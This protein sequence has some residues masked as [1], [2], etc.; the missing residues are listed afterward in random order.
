MSQFV[1]NTEINDFIEKN[2]DKYQDLKV[3]LETV[4]QFTFL[5]LSRR[6]VL[7]NVINVLN[8]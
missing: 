3:Y 1:T 8:V 6:E 7:I 5:A 4:K 2:R